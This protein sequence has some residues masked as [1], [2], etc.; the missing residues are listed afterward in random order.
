MATETVTHTATS[1]RAARPRS[2]S[3][4]LAGSRGVG[5]IIGRRVL[6]GAI[7]LLAVTALVFLLASA[8]PF[9]PVSAYLGAAD[10]WAD[11]A[12]RDRIHTLLGVDRPWWQHWWAWLSAAPGGDL[13]W[14]A[15]YRQPVSDVL[16]AR[17]PWTV[18]LGA[19]SLVLAVV[20]ASGLAVVAV[21]RPYG[22]VDR[23]LT[24]LATVLA[25]TPAFLV[26][27]ELIAVVAVGWRALPAGGL[28]E[29]GEALTAGQVLRHLLLPSIALAVS[30]LPWLVLH[31]RESLVAGYASAAV[32]GAR[33]RGV[34]ERAVL[35]VHVL[36]TAV[37]PMV[38][39]V[40]ARLPELITGAVLVEAVFGWPGAGQALVAAATA[41]DYPMLATITVVAGLVVIAG[42]L[43]ADL[44]QWRLDPRTRRA[45]R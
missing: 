32:S 6:G 34:S 38:T 21:R 9:D 12:T 15:V 45:I 7:T 14:S 40:A 19:S 8:A 20:V 25:G 30:L 39:V 1:P 13:G 41:V 28:V 22:I 29:P 42:N 16:A 26:A 43:A 31:L 4:P 35:T 23:A 5:A 10:E 18:L 37:M 2:G 17:L 3:E 11:A 44:T 24:T 33:A 27:L 36:P